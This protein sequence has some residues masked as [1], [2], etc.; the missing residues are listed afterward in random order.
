MRI[1]KRLE[2]INIANDSLRLLRGAGLAGPADPVGTGQ[3]QDADA[4][5]GALWQETEELAYLRPRG[6]RPVVRPPT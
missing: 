4:K 5:R 3:K 6:G 1:L 2:A